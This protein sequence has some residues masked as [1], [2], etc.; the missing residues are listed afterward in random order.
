M[1][2]ELQI[3]CEREC[4]NGKCEQGECRCDEG[5]RHSPGNLQN[6]EPFC[7]QICE[8]GRCIGNNRCECFEQYELVEPFVCAPICETDCVNG[9]CSAPN[10]CQCHEGYR[11]SNES[12]SECRPVCGDTDCTNGVC[13]APNECSCLDGYYPDEDNMFLCLLDAKAIL[14]PREGSERDYY[15]MSYM[16]YFIPVIACVSLILAILII[17]M[18][19]RNR[20]KNYHVGK[21]ES[22]ENCVYF[23][24]N[25][26][27]KT[28]ELTK[29]NL[30]V[31]TI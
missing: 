28:D 29:L 27:S 20:Q 7:E 31:E 3:E 8:S 13:V 2:R 10:H 11:K 16:H 26:D 6:C 18:I 17:K 1:A 4:R 12:D 23:M 21:L 22:K 14:L 19:V 25:P 5:F 24:P 15:K 30:P 9:F